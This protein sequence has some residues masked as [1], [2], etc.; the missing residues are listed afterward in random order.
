MNI[1]RSC[2]RAL[3]A[4]KE[5]LAVAFK[6]LAEVDPEA[7]FP[8]VTV[9]VGSNNSGGTTG[10]A[11]VLI[12]LE[13][14]CRSYWL[15]HNVTDRLYHLIAHEYGHVEQYPHGGE[16]PTSHTVLTES[17]VEGGAELIA[18]LISGQASDAYL[19]RW[20]KGRERVY[21]QQ[22]LAQR[23]DKDLPRWLYNGPGTAKEPGDLGYLFGYRIAKA[24]YL[25]A[26]N[27][28]LALKVLLELKNPHAI[29]AASGW[30]PG[31][32]N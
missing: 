14:A 20:A 5:K 18:E 22:F 29:L 17:L 24:Y 6:K 1:L 30:S 21:G 26:S 8:P 19:E 12:G 32:L 2:V 16:N 3:P 9:L 13:V 25:K 27:K 4:V 23:D 15:Q 11:G 10:K 31:E 7:T 28:R